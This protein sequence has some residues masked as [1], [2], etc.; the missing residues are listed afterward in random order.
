M[1]QPMGMGGMP[2][3]MHPSVP[4]SMLG[5][6]MPGGVMPGQDMSLLGILN[7]GA[8]G[9]MNLAA[10]QQGQMQNAMLNPYMGAPMAMGERGGVVGARLGTPAGALCPPA[11]SHPPPCQLLLLATSAFEAWATYHGRRG[12]ACASPR[13]RLRCPPPP[14]AHS[15]ACWRLAPRSAA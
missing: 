2:A 3:M 6:V 5:G 15:V 7:N 10:L 1:Q 12:R 14:P 4:H 9:G 11:Q 8:P 13:L